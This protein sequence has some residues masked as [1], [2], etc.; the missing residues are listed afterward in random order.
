MKKI[1]KTGVIPQ[2]TELVKAFPPLVDIKDVKIKLSVK[3][4]STRPPGDGS[5]E[6][7]KESRTHN[8]D[9]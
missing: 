2:L 4:K 1:N 7:N 8:T 9:C 6:T 3:I 5:K